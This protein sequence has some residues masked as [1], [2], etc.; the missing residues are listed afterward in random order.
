[1]ET[2]SYQDRINRVLRHIERTL[3]TRPDLA[4]LA[5]IACFSPYHFHR[6][7]SS[8]VGESVAAY[9]RRLLLER[10]AL[11]VAHT[12]EPITQIALD[13][14]YESVDAFTRAFRAHFATLPSE[15]R[16]S[17]GHLTLA[18]QKNPDTPLFHHQIIGAP[19]LDIRLVKFP[20]VLAA[21][22]RHTGPYDDSGPTWGKLLAAI[23]PTGL[24]GQ[25]TVA[26]G[27]SYDNPDVT[28]KQKCRMDACISLPASVRQESPQVR[29]LLRN[30]EIFLRH[31]GG[32]CDYVA[33]KVHG[34]YDRLHPAYRSLFGVWLP[35]S[36]REP[37]NDPGF[38]AYYN[39]PETTAPEDLLTEIFIPLKA[40]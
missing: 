38:E 34:P 7:F 29:G 12:S 25:D 21:A 6:I 33:V 40:Q 35:Q 13:A 1:M 11:Q 26:Y 16:R 36:G 31:I 10:S 27:V 30:K 22:I 5:D 2:M 19:A 20:A 39:S 4:E 28:P 14:G 9:V 17:G 8:M 15:Y 24:L 18:R 23:G 32:G 37:T 3:G